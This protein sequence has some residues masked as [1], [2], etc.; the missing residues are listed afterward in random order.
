MSLSELDL[1]RAENAI[2]RAALTKIKDGVD[3][4]QQL[5][6][7]V[8]DPEGYEKF[9]DSLYADIFGDGDDATS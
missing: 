5:A 9:Q 8:I 7:Q 6:L 4:P 3:F 2:L 1:L